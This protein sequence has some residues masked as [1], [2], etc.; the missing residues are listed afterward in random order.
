MRITR[1]CVSSQACQWLLLLFSFVLSLC[2]V[3]RIGK[4]LSK[5]RRILLFLA[6]E[7]LFRDARKI[8][9][10]ACQAFS[11]IALGTRFAFAANVACSG[12]PNVERMFVSLGRRAS[13]EFRREIDRRVATGQRMPAAGC[14]VL[15]AGLLRP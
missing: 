7:L 6:H 9:F 1:Y 3:R 5:P 14:N 11:D 10:E 8:L 12:S 4:M 2:L 15:Y 13:L